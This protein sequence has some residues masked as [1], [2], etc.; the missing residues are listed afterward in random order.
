MSRRQRLLPGMR[1]IS[2]ASGE[3]RY[4][5]TLDAGPDPVTGKRRQTRK[6]YKTLDEATA[7]HAK[8][9]SEVDAGTYVARSAVTVEQLCADYIA[10][11]HNLRA[12]SLSK[13]EYDLAPLRERHGGKA[14]QSLTKRHIDDL[15][16]DL[17]AGGAP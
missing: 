5:V 14:V 9:S 3:V 8:I 12:T 7:A 16:K 11:R 10:G 13:L 6:R 2:L 17:L 4:E 15:V 1:K